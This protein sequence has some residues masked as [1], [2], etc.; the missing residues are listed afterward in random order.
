MDHHQPEMMITVLNAYVNW[1][2][3]QG[4]DYVQRNLEK[5]ML[6]RKKQQ[7][8]TLIALPLRR[9]R[10]K[11]FVRSCWIEAELHGG[12]LRPHNHG[13]FWETC[14]SHYTDYRFEKKFRLSR[15]SFEYLC[16]QL[17]P[18]LACNNT[19]MRQAIVV[20]KRIAVA[21]IVLKGNIDFRTVADL[22]GIGKRKKK[23]AISNGFLRRWRFPDC[24]GAM[25]GTHISIL[26]P[27]DCTKDYYNYKFFHS[28]VVLAVVCYNYKFIK[29]DPTKTEEEIFFLLPLPKVPLLFPQ[30]GGLLNP[31]TLF[32]KRVD[33]ALP[34]TTN[35]PPND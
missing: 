26:A 23:I 3:L 32:D 9:R 7:Y 31:H 16:Q 19:I 34:N 14:V 13:T 8:R 29:M 28:I 5:F 25:D 22:Y 21:L 18:Y 35:R 17:T 30:A 33:G 2:K 20:P 6:I 12:E 27:S 24:F 4:E 10:R 11:S 1:L 15:A